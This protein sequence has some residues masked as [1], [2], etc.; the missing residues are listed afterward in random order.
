MKPSR[1]ALAWTAAFGALSAWLAW[2]A[3][4]STWGRESG[5]LLSGGLA[6]LLEQATPLA[7]PLYNWN[8]VL[9]AALGSLCLLAVARLMLGLARVA[10]FA[11]KAVFARRR[12]ALGE[13]GQAMTEVAVSFPVLLITT[14]ILMQLALL[15]QAKNVVTYAAF[16][17][18]RSAVVWIPA[19]ADGEGKHSM[20]V[21]G[22]PKYDKVHQAAALACVPISPR[23]SVV[24]DGMPFLGD[25][26]NAAMPAFDI[27]GSA[28][29]LPGNHISNGLERYAFSTFATQVTFYQGTE[30]GLEEV[31]D[32]ASWAYPAGPDVGVRVTH[33]YYLPIPL[34]NRLIGDTWSIIDLGPLFS[35]DLPGRYS[36]IS[37]RVVLPLEGETGNPPITGFWD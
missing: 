29:G 21:D 14:L 10:A 23:A 3:G 11:V 1:H 24:L 26:L 8:V 4:A 7:G 6:G 27:L 36:M 5:A 28:L 18:T 37:S 35:V 32:D 17:A 30:D 12:L 13:S 16:A 2:S 20:N 25:L 22:G 9:Y 33:R 19:E 34:V 15:Y 31:S